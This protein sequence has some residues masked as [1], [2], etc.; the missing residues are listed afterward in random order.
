[1]ARPL[2]QD[3]KDRIVDAAV[4]G[5]GEDG[6]E[7]T[8]IM[9]IARRAQLSIGTVYTYFPDKEAL[10]VA[11]VEN[12][13]ER[14]F[15]LMD[16]VFAGTSG[17]AGFELFADSTLVLLQELQPLVRGMMGHAKRLDLV[18]RNLDRFVVDFVGVIGRS[19]I[20]PGLDG[21]RRDA[22]QEHLRILVYGA[23]FSLGGNLAP[24]AITVEFQKIKSVFKNLVFLI[25][26]E[27]S[28]G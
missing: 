25:Q 6:Y 21:T 5:F 26:K 13:W 27:A 17:I 3:K 23:L 16:R 19:G 24:E 15:A 22:L 1:M 20:I 11:T 4:A 28:H 10:F 14:F 12:V 7:R 9:R 8:T 18:N 2:D